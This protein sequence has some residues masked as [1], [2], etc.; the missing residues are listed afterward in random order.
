VVGSIAIH[1]TLN[2]ESPSELEWYDNWAK[3]VE[4]YGSLQLTSS[5]DK[6]PA[7]SGLANTFCQKNDT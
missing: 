1:K 6:S 2:A 4:V 7:L 5:E 3:L